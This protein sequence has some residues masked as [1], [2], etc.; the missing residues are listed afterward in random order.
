MDQAGVGIR[1]I[2]MHTIKPLDQEA[3]DAAVADC[4]QIL[5]VEEH[6]KAGGLGSA[7]AESVC[8]RG[9]P[10]YIH[11]IDD[12]FGES[13]DP[14]ELLAKHHLDKTGIVSKIQEVIET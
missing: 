1:V 5:T 2:N 13:G 12:A 10:V 11:G 8:S 3:I 9:V 4:G 14:D 7:V 6:Q